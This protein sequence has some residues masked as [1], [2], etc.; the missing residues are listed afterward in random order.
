[1]ISR[2]DWSLRLVSCA[3]CET[4]VEYRSQSPVVTISRQ[5]KEVTNGNRESRHIS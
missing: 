4:L 2:W 3:R 5:G 1:M